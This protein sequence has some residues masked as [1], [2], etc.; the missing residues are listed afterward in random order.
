MSL[1]SALVVSN[2]TTG[3]GDAGALLEDFTLSAESLMQ[4]KDSVN[5]K[6]G[7]VSLKLPRVKGESHYRLFAFYERLSGNRN[8]HFESPRHETIFDD[9]SYAVDHFDGRGAKVI[10]R[11]WK[12]YILDEEVH[13]LLSKVGRYG[14]L[15]QCLGMKS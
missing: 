15:I 6:T 7:R 10:A 12:N 5:K 14:K 1:V 8:L 2:E 4:Q 9:G 11:F 3:G 13:Q